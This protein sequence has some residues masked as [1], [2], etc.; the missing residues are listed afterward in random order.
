M[1]GD[2]PPPDRPAEERPADEQGAEATTANEA[3]APEGAVT[4]TPGQHAKLDSRLGE[5]LGDAG[6]EAD[7]GPFEVT[8]S[9]H[10]PIPSAHDLATFG[11]ARLG[12]LVLG[13]V[14]RAALGRLT[15][16]DDVKSVSL[17]G[18]SYLR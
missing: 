5:A 6:P 1:N 11:L 18:S 8:V 12:D 13:R 4:L 16:R 10:G 14:D 17:M 2:C 3:A 15:A 7:A 9:F